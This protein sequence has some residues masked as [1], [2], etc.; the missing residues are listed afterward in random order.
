MTH[1]L[2]VH[3]AALRQEGKTHIHVVLLANET[4]LGCNVMVEVLVRSKTAKLLAQIALIIIG[5]NPVGELPVLKVIGQVK[6]RTLAVVVAIVELIAQLQ[7]SSLP[8]GLA[9][10]G[11]GIVVIALRWRGVVAIDGRGA[12][13]TLVE[14]GKRSRVREA[15]ACIVASSN[16]QSEVTALVAET[17]V[18]LDI[19]VY[20]SILTASC[21]LT[22][23][24]VDTAVID[25]GRIQRSIVLISKVLIEHGIGVFIKSCREVL[26]RV[27]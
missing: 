8:Q 12:V 17:A 27:T 5:K 2:I 23:T 26:R 11:T 13:V 14:A 7:E 19:T 24:I 3:L 4:E 16:T 1:I 22:V 20:R 6:G 21:R 25:P 18:E 10:H 9:P 15:L